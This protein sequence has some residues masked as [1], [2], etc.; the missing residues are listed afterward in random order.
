VQ[1]TR[2]KGPTC[3]GIFPAAET[4]RFWS[5]GKFHRCLFLFLE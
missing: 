3:P 1:E 5:D 2:F 4:K